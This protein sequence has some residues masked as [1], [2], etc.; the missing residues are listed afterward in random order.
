[1]LHGTVKDTEEFTQQLLADVG[2]TDMLYW[3]P[4]AGGGVRRRTYH[5]SPGMAR[6]ETVMEN[7]GEHS[8]NPVS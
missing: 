1:M 8:D 4:L 6:F 7:V 3:R 2:G 5:V